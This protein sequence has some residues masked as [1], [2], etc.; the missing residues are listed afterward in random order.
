M[1]P[2]STLSHGKIL[3]GAAL[4]ATLFACQPDAGPAGLVG[5]I[6]ASHNTS[7]TEALASPGWQ[8][9][10]AAFV[11]QANQPATTATR[12]YSLLGVAQ[13]W[14]VQRAEAAGGD[15]DGEEDENEG[16]R[17]R[18]ASDRGA[19]AGASAVVL[20]YL[21]SAKTQALE[22]M[23]TAQRGVG[24]AQAQLAF[25]RGEAIGRA[26]GDEIV[27]RAKA[28]GF[29]TPFAYSNVPV[30]D[31]LWFSELA[32]QSVAGGPLPGV[33]PWFLNS[34]SQFRPGPP[35]AFGS[36]VFQ[37]ALA[38][39]RAI[40]DTRTHAQDSIA[41]YWALGAATPT[42]A[43]FWIQVATAGINQHGFSER[44][45]THLYAL[46]SATMFDAQIGCWDA[47]ETYWLIRPWQADHAITVVA[48]VG[49]PNHPSYTSGHSCISSSGAEVLKVF[50]PAQRAQL[51]A[52]VVEAGLSRMYGGIHYRFDCETGQVLGRSVAHFA[53]AADR[54]G[55]S[56]LSLD[57]EERGDRR[58]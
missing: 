11:T 2:H 36:T 48:A 4:A 24:S 32:I 3:A 22:D 20:T 14:A 13:Y 29:T 46:I 10:A 44:R 41:T 26:V 17:D 27:T 49:K 37:A 54:S 19:V 5:P 16:G 30:G 8:A 38:E 58:H 18:R 39:I 34:A 40:S 43:G 42:T 55:E 1:G 56:V 6:T 12:G 52:M 28:D 33:R 23:V 45:A 53:I 25:A 51:D 7:N 21:F 50:F 35:P 15:R 9:T 57:E 31:G 47:K